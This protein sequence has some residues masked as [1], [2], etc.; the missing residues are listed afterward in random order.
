[1]VASFTLCYNK[2][3]ESYFLVF[4]LETSTHLCKT[5][6]SLR[7]R[8]GKL[9]DSLRFI[10]VVAREGM[11]TPLRFN[12]VVSKESRLIYLMMVLQQSLVDLNWNQ[13]VQKRSGA[14]LQR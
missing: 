7:Y 14:D 4:F 11:L 2:V 3:L 10:R 13:G 8:E 6:L 12:P 5:L 9:L 1:M